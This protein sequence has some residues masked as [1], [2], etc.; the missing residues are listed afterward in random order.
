MNRKPGSAWDD[1]TAAMMKSSNMDKRVPVFLNFQLTEKRA[2]LA[3][4]VR[5]AKSEERIAGYSVDQNGKIKIKKV[6]EKKKYEVINSEEE[7]HSYLN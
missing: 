2:A 5:K 1:L 3:K 4:A 6:G 7:L